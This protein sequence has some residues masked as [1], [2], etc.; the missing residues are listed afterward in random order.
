MTVKTKA[1]LKSEWKW[2]RQILAR[3]DRIEEEIKELEA[4]VKFIKDE[5]NKIEQVGED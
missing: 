3:L 5:I 4:S 1:K 2:L